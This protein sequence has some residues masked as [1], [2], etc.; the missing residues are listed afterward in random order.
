MNWG[1]DIF[2]FGVQNLLFSMLVASNLAP[3]GPSIDAGG[4]GSTRKETLGFL[5]WIS[6]DFGGNSGPPCGSFWP[7]LEDKLCFL[8]CVHA[9][10]VFLKILGSESGCLGLQNQAFGVE[11]IAKNSFSHMSGLCRFWWYFYLVFD[12]FGTNFDDFWWLGG[13]L[14]TS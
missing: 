10:Q 13:M 3:W 9:G 12:G 7:T 5:A 4:L 6:F 8:A 1:A 14:E 2:K 11:S